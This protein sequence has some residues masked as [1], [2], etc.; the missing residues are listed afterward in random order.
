MSPVIPF[1]GSFPCSFFGGAVSVPGHSSSDEG[2]YPALASIESKVR[3]RPMLRRRGIL[4]VCNEVEIIINDSGRR[5]ESYRKQ[6]ESRE[7]HH[8]RSTRPLRV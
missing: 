8:I 3:S 4:M 7:R 2:R 1:L 6:I 5:L